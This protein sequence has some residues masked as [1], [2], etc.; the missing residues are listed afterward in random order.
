[1]DNSFNVVI[2]NPVQ[3]VDF[4]KNDMWDFYQKFTMIQALKVVQILY[5]TYNYRNYSD[6]LNAFKRGHIISHKD[7]NA[8]LRIELVTGSWF[9]I[10]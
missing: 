9:T 8:A 1:M 7:D 3:V 10:S 2:D 5:S 6:F 4:L